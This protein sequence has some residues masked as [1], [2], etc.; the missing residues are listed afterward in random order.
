MVITT[1]QLLNNLPPQVADLMAG[2]PEVLRNS[3]F[4]IFWFSITVLRCLFHESRFI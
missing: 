1:L 3:C 4:P 2:L